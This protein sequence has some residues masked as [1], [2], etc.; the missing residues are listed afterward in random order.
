MKVGN[1]RVVHG[2]ISYNKAVRDRIPEIIQANGKKC[3][4]KALPDD[5]FLVELEKK[6][7]EELDE[8]RRSGEVMELVDVLEIILR[9]AELKNVSEGV[10]EALRE[11]KKT[12]RGG[13]SWNLFLIESE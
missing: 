13:F 8:Y 2:L 1:K 10:L 4:Y 12:E 3:S 5:Q 7:G 11:K 9:I 6:L